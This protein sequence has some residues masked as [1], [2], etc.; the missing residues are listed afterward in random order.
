MLD[1]IHPVSL[2]LYSK[3]IGSERQFN[4]KHNEFD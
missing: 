1:K 4:S 2:Q 3:G